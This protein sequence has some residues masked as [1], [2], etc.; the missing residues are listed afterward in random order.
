[1]INRSTKN[2]LRIAIWLLPWVLVFGGFFDDV[3]RE[4]AVVAVSQEVHSIHQKTTEIEAALLLCE[5]T[6]LPDD[7]LREKVIG[8]Y[9]TAIEMQY[10][11]PI[12]TIS[13]K[14][15]LPSSGT[16]LSLSDLHSVL[17]TNKLAEGEL[18]DQLLATRFPFEKTSL[19]MA[20]SYQSYD[21]FPSLCPLS[22]VRDEFGCNSYCSA[23]GGEHD[24][25][26]INRLLT[27]CHPSLLIPLSNGSIP[28]LGSPTSIFAL[29]TKF[30]EL[31]STHHRF[32]SISE[33]DLR[34]ALFQT[35][36]ED[37][38]ALDA[39][40]SDFNLIKLHLNLTNELTPEDINSLKVLA[41]L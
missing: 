2:V 23:V 34:M 38:N 10:E 28:A 13:Q 40:D 26:T 30:S 37:T 18:V 11:S 24:N 17:R 4:V 22:D 36:L 1:M 29:A 39:F 12:P 19:Q 15:E 9:K 14:A 6:L 32:S 16:M 25:I 7:V 31:K 35:Y 3:W 20:I 21:L 8:V 41:G 5:N 27:A 33:S